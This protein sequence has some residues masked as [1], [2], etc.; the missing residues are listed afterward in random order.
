M[1]DDLQCAL[2]VWPRHLHLPPEPMTSLASNV[3][4]IL[5][6]YMLGNSLHPCL[7]S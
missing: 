5:R 4:L 3:L 1:L 7:I 6:L 2:C